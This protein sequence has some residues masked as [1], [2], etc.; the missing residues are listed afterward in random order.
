M[1]KFHITENRF[2]KYCLAQSSIDRLAAR[3]ILD[4]NAWEPETT[5]VIS[6]FLQT[7]DIVHA[8]TYFGPL[9]PCIA[10]AGNPYQ[11]QIWAFEPNHENYLCAAETIKLNN[12]RNVNLF[13]LG[14]GE[15]NYSAKIKVKDNTGVSLGGGSHI[16]SEELKESKYAE[17]VSIVSLDQHLLHSGK[18]KG[19][20]LSLI[21]L[22]VE[23]YEGKCLLGAAELLKIFKPTLILETIPTDTQSVELLSLLHY[24]KIGSCDKNSILSSY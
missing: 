9:L 3:R 24:K 15:D 8:G 22:D 17:K 20:F 12:L 7:G 6:T 16:I 1:S 18:I 11:H 14:L 21:H 23:G 5:K 2:G 4:G 10:K 13:N 19:R